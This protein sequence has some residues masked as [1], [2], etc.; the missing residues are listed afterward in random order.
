MPTRLESE[1]H[2]LGSAEQGRGIDKRKTHGQNSNATISFDMN[3]A[4][5]NPK[6]RK[7]H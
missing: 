1:G 4:K 2:K 6:E 5:K 3:H 7:Q